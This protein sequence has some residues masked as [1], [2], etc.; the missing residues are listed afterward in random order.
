[1]AASNN[2][3]VNA[4]RKKS[5]RDLEKIERK[6]GVSGREVIERTNGKRRE[7]GGWLWDAGCEC[8]AAGEDRMHGQVGPARDGRQGGG[9]RWSEPAT[10]FPF[11]ACV[12]KTM[13]VF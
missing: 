11:C 1:M 13:G 7:T 5:D 8:Q 10:A 9:G 2:A 6:P 3:I 12:L 4:P